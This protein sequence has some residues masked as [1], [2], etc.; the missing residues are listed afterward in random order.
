MVTFACVMGL[1]FGIG[2][3]ICA[4][5]KFASYV[6]KNLAPAVSNASLDT[7]FDIPKEARIRY[8]KVGNG[9]ALAGAA[10]AAALAGAGV[11]H[12]MEWDENDQIPVSSDTDDLSKVHQDVLT[13]PYLDPV[14]SHLVGNL[15]HDDLDVSCG[16]D[17]LTDPAYSS[18]SENVFH[19]SSDDFSSSSMGMS[20]TFDS[21]SLF[22]SSSSFGSDSMFDSSFSSCDSGISFD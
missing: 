22:D 8:R 18:F 19:D 4:I 12:P 2:A 14:Q 21:D 7:R 11:F 15:Y 13:D 17:T 5:S 3:F 1:I 20:S 10:G 9:A 16:P 6:G